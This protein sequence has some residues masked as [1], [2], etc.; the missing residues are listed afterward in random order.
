M[1]FD[2][3][4]HLKEKFENTKGV[5]R[6]RKS[7]NDRSH[8]DKKIKKKRNNDLQQTTQK[9]EDRIIVLDTRMR[10]ERQITNKTLILYKQMGVK[11][12]TPFYAE[13]VVYSTWRRRHIIACNINN[14]N[15]TNTGVNSD[16][17]EG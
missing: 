6:I 9:T 5:I 17:P 3:S 7:K 15:P 1:C 12:N 14:T 4:K 11:I 16:A 13:I 10:T 2:S 8:Y